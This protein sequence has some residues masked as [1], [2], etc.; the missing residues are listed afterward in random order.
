MQAPVHRRVTEVIEGTTIPNM[1]WV[2][3]RRVFLDPGRCRDWDPFILWGDDWFRAPGGFPDH[4]HRG[5]ETV[6][7]VLE[8]GIRHADSRGNGGEIHEGDVQWMTAGRGILHSEMP[9][10]EGR[11]HAMQLWLNLPAAHKMAAPRYQSL[12]G[13]SAPTIRAPGVEIRVLS[14][15]CQGTAAS[16]LNYVP[17]TMLDLRVDA[18]AQAAL[19]LPAEYRAFVCVLE[20]ALRLGDEAT[21]VAA[22][23]VAHIPPA[24]ARGETL[25]KLHAADRTHAILIAGAPLGEPVIFGG[26]FVMN[27]PDEIA[28][29]RADLAAGTL[30]D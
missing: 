6:T 20:G 29:A 10:G 4:P 18:D 5:F 30:A 17:V 13:A 27:T 19:D 7:L 15:S 28:Q 24:N 22:G 12:S 25:L 1:T 21:R 9:V 14:G 2:E 23:Q 8:G 16:T 3:S 26:P 11:V